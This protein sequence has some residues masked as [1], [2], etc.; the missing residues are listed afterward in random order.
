[1]IGCPTLACAAVFFSGVPTFF[2]G[3]PVRGIFYFGPQL[4]EPVIEEF[5][6]IVSD[7]Y[8]ELEDVSKFARHATCQYKLDSHKA[9]EEFYMLALECSL[10]E[11]EARIVREAVR[12]VRI[13]K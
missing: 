8:K 2:S 1:L 11:Y 13:V 4:P 7:W 9:C 5:V 12:T 6:R 3:Q 10:A